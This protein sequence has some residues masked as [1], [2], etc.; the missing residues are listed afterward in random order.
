MGSSN[1]NT[2][3]SMAMTPAIATRRFCPPESS[4]GDLSSSVSCSPTK[5]AASR[6]RRSISSASS[7]MFF[8]PKAM[9]LYTV[10]SNSWYSG[11]WNTNPTLK[12]TSR[13]FF[14]SAQM[15][16]PSRRIRP[17][18]G[19]KSPFRCCISV[20][21]PDPVCP[22]TPKNS[23]APTVMLSPSTALRWNGVPAE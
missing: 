8:G 19:C 15:S 2:F 6:T 1:T 3:G 7:P 22:I 13:I 9:S 16:F 11:Y 4:K 21:L 17:D 10:S 5:A 12:R 23:P 18:V 14:G 20:D